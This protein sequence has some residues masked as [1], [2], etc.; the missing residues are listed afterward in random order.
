MQSLEE[1]TNKK[2]KPDQD[3]DIKGAE[4]ITDDPEKNENVNGDI[5][6][7]DKDAINTS[8]IKNDSKDS[9]DASGDND[10]VADKEKT[11]NGTE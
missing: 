4:E 6:V 3:A 10:V 11:E 1:K 8:E 7:V 5:K 9:N 2:E